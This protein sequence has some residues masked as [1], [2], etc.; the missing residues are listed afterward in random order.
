MNERI[1]V[2]IGAV[3]AVLL[4]IVVA[5]HIV[6][7]SGMPNVI[8]VFV[9]LMSVVRPAQASPVMAFALGLVYD[10]FCG[11]PV[12][13]MA[14]C[15]T[16]FST[17]LSAFLVRSGNDSAFMAILALAVGLLLVEFSYGLFLLMFGFRAGLLDAIAYRVV[18]CFVYDLVLGAAL[19][20][21][22][23]R[24]LQTSDSS[25]IGITQLR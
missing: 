23:M 21:L 17:A 8:A 20:P 5:P 3:A 19:Y 7:L 4:Q 12:G 15:L 2:I 10:F 1:I 25:P 18:P 9:L 16:A 13:S 22:A 24:F 14:F 6:I 11:G